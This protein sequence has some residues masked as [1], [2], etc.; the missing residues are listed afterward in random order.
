ME[1]ISDILLVAGALGAGL[2]CF[3]LARR[4]KR[5]TDL[6]RG[7]GGAI[8]V[9]SAQAEELKNSLGAA[10]SASD[11]SGKK[12]QDLTERAETVA[13]QLELIMASMHDVVPENRTESDTGIVASTLPKNAEQ[14]AMESP[15]ERDKPPAEPASEVAGDKLASSFD[16]EDTVAFPRGVMFFRHKPQGGEVSNK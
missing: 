9:L 10:R 12:L 16:N 13:Q 11:Q 4:L 8:S 7:V 6:E 5:F 3:I 15:P 14:S 2:Y 1:L